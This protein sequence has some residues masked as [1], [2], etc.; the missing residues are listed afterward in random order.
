MI[1]RAD[2]PNRVGEKAASPSWRKPGPHRPRAPR[3]DCWEELNRG[4]HG[5]EESAWRVSLGKSGVSG[6]YNC[7]EKGS[8]ADA[9]GQGPTVRLEGGA[10]PQAEGQLPRPLQLTAWSLGS[11]SHAQ[12]KPGPA[13]PA[14]QGGE[15]EPNP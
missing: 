15:G 6:V 4:P 13:F 1:E 3:R 14:S 8:P 2:N 9:E 10:T 12:V 5:L 11:W 7:R